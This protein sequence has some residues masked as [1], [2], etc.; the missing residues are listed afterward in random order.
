MFDVFIRSCFLSLWFQ[1][2]AFIHALDNL[3]EKF[4]HKQNG[5]TAEMQT[6][7]SSST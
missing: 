7:F 1:L 6:K 2:T 5:I 3:G 4:P